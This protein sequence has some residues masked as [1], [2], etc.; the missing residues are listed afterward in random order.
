MARLLLILLIGGAVWYGWRLFRRQQARVTRDLR[1][2]E[3][4]IAREKTVE[5]ERDP[6]TGVY[7][8]SDRRD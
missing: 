7:R 4:T 5:L 2:A 6:K 1:D 8:P 3:G